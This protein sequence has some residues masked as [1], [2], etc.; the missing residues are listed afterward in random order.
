[1]KPILP[2]LKE[3]K[4]YLSFDI[5][6]EGNFSVDEVSKAI[7]DSTYLGTLENSKAGIIFLKDKYKNNKGIIKTSHKYVDKV[8]TSL[9]LIKDIDDHE[10]I[11]R[12]NVVSGILKKAIARG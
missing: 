6:S 3:K 2:S 5:I 4:R 7:E 1:M 8:R 11:F 10:V 12:T 9:A